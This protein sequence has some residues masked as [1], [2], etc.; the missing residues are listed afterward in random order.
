MTVAGLPVPHESARGH[1]TGEALYTDDLVGRFPQTLHA[2]PVLAPHAH[3]LVITL[4]AA[5]ALAEPGV[6][7][8]L[9]ESDVPGKGNSGTNRHDEPLF[10]SEVMY[11]QQPVAWVLGES[12]EAAQRG[13]ARVQVTYQPLPAILTIEEAIAEPAFHS[14]PFHLR[15]G[16]A[17]AAVAGSALRIQG[18][19][20]IGGQEHFYLETQC[21]LAWLDESGGVA[22][23]SSTQHPSE[24]QD[25]VARVLGLARSQVTV[26]CLRMGGAFGGK[27][28]QA[29]PWAAVAALGA[30]KT[31]RPVRVRLPRVLDMA[32][33][34]KRHPFLARFAAGFGADGRLQGLTVSLYSDAGWSLDLSEPVMWR[35]MFHLDNAYCLPAVDVEGYVCRTHKT[36][37]TAFRGFGGPQGMLVIEDILDRAARRLSLPPELV[38]QRNFY[39][40]GQ[41]TH[42][43]QTVK[44][45]GRIQTIWD[46]LQRTSRFAER[47]KAAARFNAEHPHRKRGIAITPVKFGISFTATFF[48]QAGALVL[49]YRDGSVQ[50]NHGGTEMGQGLHTKIRQIAAESLGLPLDSVRIM[51]T[52]TDKVPNTSA[53]AASASTDLNGAAVADACEQLKA[54]LSPVA[55]AM[56]GCPPEAVRYGGG[57]VFSAVGISEG[58]TARL[59]FA[60]VVEAAY[61]QRLPLFAQGYYRTPG[62]HFDPKTGQGHPFHY[63]AY[64]AGVTEVE[65]DGFTGEHRILRVDILH[66][67]GDSISPVIDRGQVEGGFM[68]GLGWLTLEELL[69]DQQGRVATAGASTYKLPSWAELPEVFE[70]AFLQRATEAGVILGSKAVGEPPLMLAISVREAIRDA[71]AAFGPRGVQGGGVQVNLDSPLTPERIFWAIERQ[72]F[73]KSLGWVFEHSPWVAERAWQAEPFESVDTLH[74][75]MTGQVERATREEQLALLRAH[76]DLGTRVKMSEASSGEQAGAGLDCLT[77]AECARLQQLNAEYRERF[78][79]PFLLA[80]KGSTKHDILRALE[81]R[82]G[83]TRDEEFRVAL[84]QVYR[85][86]RFRLETILACSTS[87]AATNGITTAKATL[88]SI[89]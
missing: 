33:T 40:D 74:A 44:D 84:D 83:G 28:V 29:N 61:R 36:S 35:A 20:H 53:S 38:R 18:E 22:L 81:Q 11:H 37:Q 46:E 10:P 59:A 1:V 13:A 69:W 63:F 24:T 42:Y 45:A 88:S 76:P 62:I 31:R 41:T 16:D 80:V 25:V 2:W 52:R 3:A 27:E 68:Q 21:A 48:N 15:R 72:R 66:D 30:W 70:V 89:G 58:S 14:G 78:G 12:L 7:A 34:G 67:V 19:L 65:V 71:I 79:F 77:P 57:S 17:A 50:V 47:H 6:A 73:V 82:V 55:G 4:D 8:T 64:G 60:Q 39:R 56:L 32:L 49:I 43:G 51:P 23:H 5:P 87:P 86:A 75:A 54:R 9:T 26:E 85:I